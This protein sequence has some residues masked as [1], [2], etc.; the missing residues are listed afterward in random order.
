MYNSFFECKN[1]VSKAPEMPEDLTAF[2]SLVEN[3]NC[4]VV[5]KFDNLIGFTY[6]GGSNI[7]A[8]FYK[9]IDLT[10]KNTLT[11][12]VSSL[13]NS[14]NNYQTLAFA[15]IL[16]IENTI[17]PSN[18]YVALTNPQS[19][20]G[21]TYRQNIQGSFTKFEVD[22]SELTGEYWVILSSIGATS[23]WNNLFIE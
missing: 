22:V 21:A 16:I 18:N 20:T 3:A 14:Y 12:E 1:I 13:I 6:I 10:D 17:D 8:Q 23:I 5:G 7:A 9:K 15:P 19:V 11:I 4:M 2:T